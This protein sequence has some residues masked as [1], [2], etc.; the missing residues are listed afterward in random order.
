M[1]TDRIEKKILLRAPLKRVWRAITDS[2]EFRSWFG[3]QL[4]GPITPGA[5]LRGTIVGTTVDA[6]VGKSQQ[7]HEGIVF[8]ITIEKME[9]EK[10]FSYRWHPHA[11]ERGTD[12]SSEPT[13]LVVF[14]LEEVAGGVMLTVIESGFDQIPLARRT[15]AFMANDQGWSVVVKLL[16]GYLERDQ[17]PEQKH[18]QKHER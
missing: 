5:K 15:K 17:K 4:D 14:E 13:T 6:E 16:D 9:R 7:K 11:I 1:S 3:I 12:Y 8:D 10:L 2:L 18:E